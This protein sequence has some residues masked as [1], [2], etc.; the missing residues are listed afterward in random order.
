VPL[1]P[2]NKIIDGV[3]KPAAKPSAAVK[4]RMSPIVVRQQPGVPPAKVMPVTLS[5]ATD[6]S[7]GL[8]LRDGCGFRRA[9]RGFTEIEIGCR[10][11][12]P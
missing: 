4:R 8:R 9:H 7:G 6:V 11:N 2:G 3:V 5:N 12:S 1:K 10:L